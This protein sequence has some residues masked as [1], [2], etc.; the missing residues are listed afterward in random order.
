MYWKLTS[1]AQP[2]VFSSP[3]CTVQQQVPLPALMCHVTQL[4]TIS[5]VL[6]WALTKYSSVFP[7]LGSPG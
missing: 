7:V 1:Q 3:K 5:K 2:Q 4:L 6:E